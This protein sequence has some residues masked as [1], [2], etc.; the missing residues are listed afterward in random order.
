MESEE[1]KVEQISTFQAFHNSKPD[2]DF[3]TPND[4]LPP[5]DEYRQLAMC[6]SIAD[7]NHSES[8]R[9]YEE[10]PLSEVWQAY[11]IKRAMSEAEKENIE[12]SRK[13]AEKQSKRR[14]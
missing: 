4:L 1:G 13:K 14:F 3:V 5:S 6:Y 11:A 2:D 8:K 10:T 12:I 9:L 7:G